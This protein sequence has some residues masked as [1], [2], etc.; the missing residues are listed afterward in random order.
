MSIVVINNIDTIITPFSS[1]EFEI[2]QPEILI[3]FGGMVVSKRIKAALRKNQPKHH[4][5]I[6]T[7]RAYNTYGCLT[8][9]FQIN[10]NDF[11]NQ[12]IPLLKPIES[13]YFEHFESEH[14]VT[15]ANKDGTSVASRWQK[16]NAGVL[17][18]MWD[19]RVYNMAMKEI[20]VETV[21]KELKTP[22]LTWKEF[23]A[24]I[25]RGK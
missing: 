11:F 16:K 19:V 21:R 8:E 13:D 10:P 14:C 24:V 15:E 2:F 1:S 6:D 9:H 7:L 17:N 5:H 25:T 4:W 20:I 18:H 23:V 3:T 22:K 12:F